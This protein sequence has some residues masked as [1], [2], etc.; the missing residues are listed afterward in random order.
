MLDS[1]S[2]PWVREICGRVAAR[3]AAIEGV[4]ALALG[5]SRARGTAHKD[6][7][8]DVALY[9]HSAA[10]FSIDRREVTTQ[11]SRKKSC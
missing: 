8:I 6:S 7:D 1:N 2:P 10:A 9:Y 5:R 11:C 4:K 3:L